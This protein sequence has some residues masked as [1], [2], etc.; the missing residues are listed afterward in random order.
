MKRF[1]FNTVCFIIAAI[2][3]LG[4]NTVIKAQTTCT[5][6]DPLVCATLTP[7]VGTTFTGGTNTTVTP[8]GV[9]TV[10]TATATAVTPTQLS[11]TSNTIAVV[12]NDGCVLVRFSQAG[13]ATVPVLM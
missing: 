2:L 8:V 1:Y 7:N 12:G 11:I 5:P 3:L 13:T 6:T 10:F 4:S 9:S